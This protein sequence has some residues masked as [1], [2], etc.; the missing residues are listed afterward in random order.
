MATKVRDLFRALKAKPWKRLVFLN[1]NETPGDLRRQYDEFRELRACL[2]QELLSPHFPYPSIHPND[3]VRHGQQLEEVIKAIKLIESS[4]L[5]EP[6][7]AEEQLPFST[8]WSDNDLAVV[9]AYADAR[10]LLDTCL[11]RKLSR[12]A[13]AHCNDVA[14]RVNAAMRDAV[15]RQFD[16]SPRAEREQKEAFWA[17][18]DACLP[19]F[20]RVAHGRSFTQFHMPVDTDQLPPAA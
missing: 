7:P 11:M 20:P 16:A 10:L 9:E 5:I 19:T 8:E 6:V 17:R 15:Q 13:R 1:G 2:T 12:F 3:P 18:V 14:I 4:G